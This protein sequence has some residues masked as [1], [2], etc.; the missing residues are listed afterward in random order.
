[1]TGGAA[2]RDDHLIIRPY[3]PQDEAVVVRLWDA[4]NLR[5]P[6]NDVAWDIAFCRSSE[7]NSRL[8]VGQTGTDVVA[9][10]MVGHDGH[11]GWLYYVAVD[12]ELRRQGI[13]RRMVAHAEAWLATLG[14]WKTHLLIRQTNSGMKTFYE[15]LGYE[16]A[17][18]IMMA[19]A[20]APSPAFLDPLDEDPA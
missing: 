8:F 18:R 3:E 20:I 10:V 12:P 14:V 7:S 19:K 4:C 17:P 11:R 6:Y 9:S 1:M 13:G 15:S 5:V 16:V 2:A